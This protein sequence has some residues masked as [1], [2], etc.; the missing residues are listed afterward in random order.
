M[1]VF[2]LLVAF[3]EAVVWIGGWSQIV[4][5]PVA[6]LRVRRSRPW[7]DRPDGVRR[8]DLLAELIL[9]PTIAAIALAWLTLIVILVGGLELSSGQYL[10]LIWGP[11]T[12]FV[13]LAASR[14]DP[15]RLDSVI[16][17]R[18]GRAGASGAADSA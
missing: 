16:A 2:E 7:L 12:V 15:A 17:E 1:S 11:P 10:A 18:F 6:W 4:G 13:P 8:I 9:V 5:M 3:V 14:T